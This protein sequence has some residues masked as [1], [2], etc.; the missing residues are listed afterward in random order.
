MF[1]G[2]G[3]FAQYAA[4]NPALAMHCP[5]P[6][7]FEQAAAIPGAFT[8]AWTGLVACGRASRGDWVLLCGATSGVGIAALQIAK[9]MGA[10]VIA[11]SGSPGKLGRL[12]ALG[13]DA[14]VQSRGSGFVKD[15]RQITGGEGVNVSLN[16]IGAT[17]FQGCVEVAADFGRVV[18]VGYVDGQLRAECDLEAVHGRRLVLTGTS[19]APMSP[20]QRADAQQGFLRDVFPALASGAIV[21][22]IDR[23]FEFDELPA[24][25]RYFDNHQQVGKII[26]RIAQ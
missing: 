19:N 2:R 17:A 18:L 12:A 22:V 11:T 21:P 13:A 23:V 7:S 3:C 15:V 4:V 8:T 10:K 5:E 26:V 9:H 20:T 1:L 16:M 24:A 25:K 6:M 14:I